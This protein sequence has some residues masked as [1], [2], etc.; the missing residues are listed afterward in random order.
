MKSA[1]FARIDGSPGDS[2]T[3]VD[4]STHHPRSTNEPPTTSTPPAV[5]ATRA[6]TLRGEA[7]AADQGGMV[8][9]CP[10]GHP[11]PPWRATT[12]APHYLNCRS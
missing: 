5:V 12:A 7:G 9:V 8:K 6:G 1:A 3:S 4:D 10:A 11:R 2:C